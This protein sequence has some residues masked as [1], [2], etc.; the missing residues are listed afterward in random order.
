M[1][2]FSD[3]IAAGLGQI[4]QAAGVPVVFFDGTNTI[5]IDDAVPLRGSERD[6]LGNRMALQADEQDWGIKADKIAVNGVRIEPLSG[7]TIT[8]TIHGES[9]TYALTASQGEKPYTWSDPDG[10]TT[11]RL[12]SKLIKRV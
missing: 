3:Q 9:L 11:Y 8:R 5:E 7:Y 4:R 12:H 6:E 2:W 10:R 1:S